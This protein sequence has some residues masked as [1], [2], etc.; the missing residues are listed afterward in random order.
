MTDLFPMPEKNPAYNSI[1][2]NDSNFAFLVIHSALRQKRSP[3]HYL[4]AIL[5][6]GLISLL[7]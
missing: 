3:Q 7:C 1:A 5:V 2:R 6:W 4:G